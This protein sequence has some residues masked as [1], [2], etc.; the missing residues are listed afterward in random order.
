[1]SGRSSLARAE[2][3]TGPA[4][5]ARRSRFRLPGRVR[6]A[7]FL[8]GVLIAAGIGALALWLPQ[9][10]SG[11]SNVDPPAQWQRP[12]VSAAGLAERSGVRLVR[13]A[14]TGGGGLLDL[15]YQVVD[16]N[17]A[18]AVHEERTPP[19]IIDERTGLVLNRLLMGHAHHGVLK[20]A[21]SYYLIFEN[22]GDWVRHGSEVTVLLGDAQ[23]E[24]VVVK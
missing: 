22:T 3:G 16:P 10:A 9:R 2:P 11:G 24:H 23:V 7:G 6:I 17:K 18:V 19:A 15:R 5:P 13:V 12:S 1:M 21:V 20:A 8:A 4:A 14:V